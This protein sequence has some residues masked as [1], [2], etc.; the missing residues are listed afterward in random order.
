MQTCRHRQFI[1]FC[2]NSGNVY[3]TT[4]ELTR[5]PVPIIRDWLSKTLVEL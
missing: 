4:N 2:S 1:Q 3:A 5:L